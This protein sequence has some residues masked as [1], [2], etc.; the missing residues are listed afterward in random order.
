MR[1]SS[2]LAGAC[3]YLGCTTASQSSRGGGEGAPCSQDNGNLDCEVGLYCVAPPNRF[4]TTA[5]DV[6]CPLPGDTAPS[7]SACV[8][9]GSVDA[10]NPGPPDG[11]SGG[12]TV[13]GG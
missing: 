5:R 7:A 1:A 11:P 6:C 2:L 9:T 10:G 8:V 12:S 4:A 13:D 3:V